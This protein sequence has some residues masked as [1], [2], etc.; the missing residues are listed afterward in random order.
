MSLFA[1]GAE[2]VEAADMASAAVSSAQMA[3]M[4]EL[5][6]ID[7]NRLTPLEAMQ[8]IYDW[9]EKVRNL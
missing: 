3:V 2:G 7:V 8:L 9:Q 6:E 1:P 4:Q 5:Q